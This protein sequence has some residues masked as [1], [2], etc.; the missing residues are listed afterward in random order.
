MYCWTFYDSYGPLV[1][2]EEM[3]ILLPDYTYLLTPRSRVLENLTVSHLV[4]K[5]LAFYGTRM[6]ITAFT[7]SRYLSL[8]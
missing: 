2:H 6:F 1:M 4:K 3:I 8:F 5:F 7:S